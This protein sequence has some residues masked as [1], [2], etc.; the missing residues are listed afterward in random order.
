MAK[1]QDPD[2][3]TVVLCITFLQQSFL[4][5][6][7]FRN[8]GRALWLKISWE[9]GQ[10][11]LWNW[12]FLSFWPVFFPNFIVILSLIQPIWDQVT[13]DRLDVEMLPNM[14]KENSKM[15][16]FGPNCPLRGLD[17]E[18]PTEETLRF[19]EKVSKFSPKMTIKLGKTPKGQIDPVSGGPFSQTR[20]QKL[21]AIVGTCAFL[22][23]CKSYF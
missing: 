15:G 17:W 19:K 6:C 13:S 20:T 5:I 3:P 21:N 1:V 12:V 11:D 23:L 14:G 7:L 4:E 16:R 9:G 2:S 18:N 8:P 10:V 22:L